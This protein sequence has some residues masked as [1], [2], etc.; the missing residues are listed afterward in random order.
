[1]LSIPLSLAAVAHL[2]SIGVKAGCDIQFVF[3][4]W[5]KVGNVSN[6]LDMSNTNYITTIPYVSACFSF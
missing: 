2:G 1:M 6:D 3:K 5:E 4:G